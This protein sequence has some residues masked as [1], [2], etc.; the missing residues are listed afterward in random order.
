MA[1][2]TVRILMVED[3]VGVAETVLDLLRLLGHEVTLSQSGEEALPLLDGGQSFDI[4]IS[5]V[6]MP[7]ISG[8]DLACEV[9]KRVPGIR[10]ILTS[11]FSANA[12]EDA[13]GDIQDYV[14]LHKPYSLGDLS[15][16]IA[17]CLGDG[18]AG[19]VRA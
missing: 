2:K 11:G 3:E 6:V 8:V 12:L 19:E 4:L 5:D 13:R 7:G 16:S 14:F 9:R 17:R 10:V 15:D 18:A 1:G